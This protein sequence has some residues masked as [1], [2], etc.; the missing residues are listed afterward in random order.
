MQLPKHVNPTRD[1]RTTCAPYNFVPLPDK[2]VRVQGLPDHDV[3]TSNSG[4][5]DVR[6]T[7]RSPIYV[8]AT[9]TP[10]EASDAD[11]PREGDKPFRERIRNKP[12]FYSMDGS[13]RI[14]G[15]SIRGMLR[16][17]V[18]IVSYSR[19]A[20]VTN[21]PMFFRSLGTDALALYYRKR[22]TSRQAGFLQHNG[23]S[24]RLV[25]CE[26]AQVWGETVEDRFGEKIHI[27]RAD[28]DGDDE[29]DPMRVPNRALQ[30]K[31]VW[32]DPIAIGRIN[33]E[34]RLRAL[35][36]S[37][38]S[39][40]R[41]V[42]WT[43]G[44]LVISGGMKNKKREFVFYSPRP[45]ASEP[46]PKEIIDRFNADD[47]VTLWQEKAFP[48]DFP[49][50]NARRRNGLLLAPNKTRTACGGN[51]EPVFY[52]KERKELVFFGRAGMFRL[53]YHHSP[54][55]LLPDDL[56]LPNEDPTPILD[57]AQALFGYINT[58]PKVKERAER[59]VND[60]TREWKQGCRNRAY[61]SRISV[62]DARCVTPREAGWWLAPSGGGRSVVPTTV[63][64]RILGSPKP[65]AYAHYLVQRTDEERALR[66]YDPLDDGPPLTTVRGYKRFWHQGLRTYDDLISPTEPPRESKQHT[67]FNPVGVGVEFRFRVHFENLSNTE[68]G[69]L[70]WAL[71]PQGPEGDDSGKPLEFCHQIGMGKP[72]GMGAVKLE[73]T[74][75]LI[76][77]TARY[78]SLFLET[79]DGFRWETGESD[80]AT[81][82][83]PF[84]NAFEK[85][86]LDELKSSLELTGT[87]ERLYDLER[88]E[89]LLRMM[90]WPG[91]PARWKD[92]R[93]GGNTR[94]MELDEYRYKPV[95]PNPFD[96]RF[97]L[98]D[99]RGKRVTTPDT[100]ERARSSERPQTRSDER[101][102]AQT[103]APRL[104]RPVLPPTPVTPR[105][106]SARKGDFFTGDLLED[107]KFEGD[108]ALLSVRLQAQG[109]NVPDVVSISVDRHK[110][111]FLR[112]RSR[113]RVRVKTPND[114]PGK[115]VFEL[116]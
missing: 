45:T 55:A 100:I 13:P 40:A 82:S 48:T 25:P 31:P 84:I 27:G 61:A 71:S 37:E 29:N 62:T 97:T 10:E 72:F 32:I 91:I 115:I 35:R 101:R 57:Y 50:E 108:R 114:D 9:F 116:V 54:S 98:Q 46:V 41:R 33:R 65:T 63:C 36:D 42:G 2:I 5:F 30:Y 7:T 94:Y 107:P 77:R 38:W 23:D 28:G 66:T 76:D 99:W 73:P 78:K 87:P 20:D 60:V 105:G 19:P 70:C 8:R 80:S 16:S 56:Q 24:Y 47:Q 26:W 110:A 111:Q 68:L 113:L 96:T 43:E 92:P 93:R 67:Q 1:E 74:L 95:L 104:A 59:E 51:G 89:T 64:P 34:R 39:D 109:A 3:F 86:I 85:H 14:P 75:H 18:E 15:S 53:P 58:H 83:T 49:S 90:L 81:P 79:E 112:I 69:A 22:M 11:D 21:I 12:D 106:K 88:I 17:L 4:Y 44:W 52:L 103:Q 102:G 6:L